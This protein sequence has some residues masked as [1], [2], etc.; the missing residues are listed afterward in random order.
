VNV[1]DPGKPTFIQS[2]YFTGYIVVRVRDYDGVPGE[3]GVKEDDEEYFNTGDTR[4][5][6]SIMFGG[7]FHS[8]PKGEKS[9]TPW[10]VDD[11][12]FGVRTMDSLFLARWH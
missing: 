7:W 1:N 10:T 11:V 12:V 8:K 3:T 9:E 4:D 5:T 2:E 6:C